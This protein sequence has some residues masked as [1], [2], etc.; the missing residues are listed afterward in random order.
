MEKQL[1]IYLSIQWNTTQQQKET[2]HKHDN[3]DESQNNWVKLKKP[4]LPSK[5]KKK[6]KKRLHDSIYIKL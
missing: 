4:D 3:T 2:T 5:K 6:K 1:V